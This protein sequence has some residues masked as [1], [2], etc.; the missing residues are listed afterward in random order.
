MY[1][2]RRDDAVKRPPTPEKGGE[3]SQGE[4]CGVDV[5]KCATCPRVGQGLRQS[6]NPLI[7]IG[8]NTYGSCGELTPLRHS[9]CPGRVSANTSLSHWAASWRITGIMEVE[10]LQAEGRTGCLTLARLESQTQTF[11]GSA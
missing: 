2:D 4:R 8:R 5:A 11:A 6:E 7:V 3:F 10:H 1:G 9:A